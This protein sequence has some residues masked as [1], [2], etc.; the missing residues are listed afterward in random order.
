MVHML[1]DKQLCHVIMHAADKGRACAT[2]ASQVRCQERWLARAACG[3]A[4]NAC[5]TLHRNLISSRV[6]C[7]NEG[8]ICAM[9]LSR[10]SNTTV[11][12]SPVRKVL[13]MRMWGG[14]TRSLQ[15]E[16]LSF[17]FPGKRRE[18]TSLDDKIKSSCFPSATRRD[19]CYDRAQ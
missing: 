2:A 12:R 3:I 5:S 10:L 1:W 16:S 6:A 7:W 8:T 11:R 9:S 15:Q 18:R 14:T 17:A 4:P 19:S 13:N